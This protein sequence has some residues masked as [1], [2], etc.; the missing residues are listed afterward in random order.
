[1]PGNS[2]Y[3]TYPEKDYTYQEEDYLSR[4]L[5]TNCG[6]LPLPIVIPQQRPGSRER[7]FIAAY[8]PSLEA[9]GIDRMTFLRFLDECNTAVQGNKLLAGVQVVSLGVG[10]TP[11]VIVM[12][13]AT[14]VQAGAYVANKGHVRHK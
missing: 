9:C 11:E 3:K 6:P 14:A 8:A 1:M 13:V 7:G 2:Y 10:F 4:Q 12:G 5:L